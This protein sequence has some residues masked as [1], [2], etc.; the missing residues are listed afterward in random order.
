[1]HL[2]AVIELLFTHRQGDPEYSTLG[3][4]AG[5]ADFSAHLQDHRAAD[6]QAKAGAALLP[7]I[8]DVCL[9]KRAKDAPLKF[10]RDALP[11]IFH[12]QPEVAVLTQDAHLH[13]RR[14]GGEL[15]GI[16]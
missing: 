2:F 5:E 14:S 15:S 6:V 16:R 9:R 7:G 10:E 12:F 13:L 11:V 3:G 4:G 8:A 1:M